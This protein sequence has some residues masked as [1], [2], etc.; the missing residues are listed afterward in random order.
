[1]GSFYPTSLTV[2]EG[3]FATNSI[4]ITNIHKKKKKNKKKTKK[5]PTTKT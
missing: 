1:M 2:C 5:Q 4:H 3:F